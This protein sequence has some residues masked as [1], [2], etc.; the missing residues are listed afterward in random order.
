VLCWPEPGKLRRRALLS[1][2]MLFFNA[3]AAIYKYRRLLSLRFAVDS[4][5]VDSDSVC[6]VP[7]SGQRQ[8]HSATVGIAT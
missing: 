6:G 1:E 8:A 4:D 3:Q 2:S 7:H 5:S